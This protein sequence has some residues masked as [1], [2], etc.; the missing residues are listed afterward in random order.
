MEAAFC[1]AVR[2]TLVGS[3]TPAFTRSSYCSVD[4]LKPKLG[5]VLALDLLDHHRALGPAVEH[6]LADRLLA[7]AAHDGDAELFVALELELLERDRSSQ[8]RDAPARHDAFLDR[9]AS[10]MQSVL[11]AG[12]LLFHLGFGG[13]A[14]LDDRHAAGQLRQPL[15]QFLAIVIR[16]GLFDLRP[17]LLDPAFDVLLRSAAVDDGGVVLIHRDALG[18]AQILQLD[19]FQLDAGLFHDGLAAGQDRDIF[20]HG[21]AA[22]AEARGSSRRKH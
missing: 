13:G 18:A 20:Q 8:Q 14:D 2:V 5:S 15:L 19:A 1:R 12:L 10:G 11:D 22:V 4:A 17:E 7:G 16:G 21:L 3:I 9:R 6:D